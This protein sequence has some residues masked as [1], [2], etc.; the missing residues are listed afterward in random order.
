MREEDMLDGMLQL[1]EKLLLENRTFRTRRR[2][3][4]VRWVLLGLVLAAFLLMAYLSITYRERNPIRFPGYPEGGC[5]GEL[6]VW[7]ETAL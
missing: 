4:W 6:Y 5:E 7:Q 1:D 3:T 2:V